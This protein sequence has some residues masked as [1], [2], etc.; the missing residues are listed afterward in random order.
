MKKT[1]LSAIILFCVHCLFPSGV[2][3]QS[4]EIDLAV[5]DSS[6]TFPSYFKE[7]LCDKDSNIYIYIWKQ[8][9][10]FNQGL[11]S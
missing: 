3:A 10:L 11:L 5:E 1:I 4:M 7:I 8:A 6:F 9:R 2:I